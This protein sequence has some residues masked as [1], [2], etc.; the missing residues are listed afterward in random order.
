MSVK[1]LRKVLN[2]TAVFV[3]TLGGLMI[4]LLSLRKPLPFGLNADRW[5]PWGFLLV[6][7][8]VVLWVI[9]V[10][11]HVS[12]E[13]PKRERVSGPTVMQRLR[14][15]GVQWPL[16]SKKSRETALQNARIT[17]RG[18]A[19]K[20]IKDTTDLAD[21]RVI[22][23]NARA[24]VDRHAAEELREKLEFEIQQ[25]LGAQY[26]ATRYY[27][28]L[29]YGRVLSDAQVLDTNEY[30]AMRHSLQELKPSLM[31]LLTA[32]NG[33]W[34]GMLQLTGGLD[35][36]SALAWLLWYF[37]NYPA[38]HSV[39]AMRDFLRFV[40]SK[41]RDPR[42]YLAGA[43]LCYKD[44]REWLLRLVAML[45]RRPDEL[46][47]YVEWLIAED[48]FLAELEKKLSIALLASVKKELGVS[49]GNSK[50]RFASPKPAVPL[51]DSER[52]A[53]HT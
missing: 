4:G 23:A 52:Q 42:P 17:E 22:D 38:L 33:T 8:S 41:E 26:D 20:Q 3:L 24:A 16:Y 15:I 45:E 40:D 36:N 6:G 51:T 18:E 49:D 35:E 34:T 28:E 37:R 48:E 43:Y 50:L 39:N 19:A 9:N 29:T 5:A 1:T 46:P 44:W 31:R 53:Q 7:A 21:L 25:R 30:A 11:L 47:G 12:E 32:A 10:I 27:Q 13:R 14:G 2:S